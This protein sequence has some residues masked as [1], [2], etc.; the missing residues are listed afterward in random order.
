MGR[1][2]DR[3]DANR[4]DSIESAAEPD[5]GVTDPRILIHE[6]VAVTPET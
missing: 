3:P 5:S 1:N 4:P 6:L 2:G